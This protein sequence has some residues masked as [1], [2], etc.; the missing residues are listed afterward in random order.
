MRVMGIAVPFSPLGAGT[1]GKSVLS[2]PRGKV[3][4][5]GVCRVSL[6]LV[7]HG[8]ARQTSEPGPCGDCS[9]VLWVPGPRGQH[10]D[11]NSFIE[12]RGVQGDGVSPFCLM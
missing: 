3:G 11:K 8:R 1:R 4:T 10:S 7:R 12:K 6:A 9:R 2:N 5:G